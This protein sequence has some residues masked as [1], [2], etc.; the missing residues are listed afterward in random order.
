MARN[1]IM[2]VAVLGIW[3]GI[4]VFMWFAAGRS[5]AT[6]ER[7]LLS[8]N[9]QYV[10]ITKPLSP[11]ETRELL[12]NLASEIN[13]TY[14]SAYGWTQVV[15]AIALLFLL[16]RQTPRDT[17]A[18]VITG[19]MLAIVLVLAVV[20][21]PQIIALGR[22]IDFVPRNPPPPEMGRFGMLHGAYT[23][24]DGLKLLAGLGLLVRWIVRG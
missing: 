3:I 11:T 21:T 2:A 23:G 12:R 13:R 20:V 17:A 4:T 9:P 7:V 22:S 8:Q 5:F 15:L 18:L 1:Q 19:A 6:V 10:K 14:F 24:L 16:L